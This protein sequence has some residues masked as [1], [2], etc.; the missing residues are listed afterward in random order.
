MKKKYEN[1]LWEV[2]KCM[3][4]IPL[5][6]SG[7]GSRSAHI[8]S[9][10]STCRDLEAVHSNVTC[11]LDYL[12]QLV[13]WERQIKKINICDRDEV[14]GTIE[15]AKENMYRYYNEFMEW[16]EERKSQNWN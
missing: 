15:Y 8:E 6:V 12:Q 3:K 11:F 10:V 13:Y 16:F 2:M 1:M 5:S 4:Q 7:M 14:E 9:Y